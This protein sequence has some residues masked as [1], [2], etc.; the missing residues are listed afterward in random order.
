M[1]GAFECAQTLE[2]LNKPNNGAGWR[3]CV[4][5]LMDWTEIT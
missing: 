5:P 4:A 3:I 2:L 1:T